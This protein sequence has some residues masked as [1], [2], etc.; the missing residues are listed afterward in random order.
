VKSLG[1]NGIVVQ[2]ISQRLF[3]RKQR[4][5]IISKFT[6]WSH[7]LSG[8]LQGWMLGLIMFIIYINDIDLGI[9]SRILKCTDDTKL[10]NCVGTTDDI[11]CFRNDLYKLCY[12]SGE[13]L[14]F[15]LM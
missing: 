11:T 12:W 10:F 7:V 13:W 14:M 9:N 15:F 5:V 8:V 4:V 1:I 3:D 2:W 6:T